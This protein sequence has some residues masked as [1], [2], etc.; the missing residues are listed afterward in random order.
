[1]WNFEALTIRVDDFFSNWE[2]RNV[3][4]SSKFLSNGWFGCSSHF[5]V[6]VVVVDI[7]MTL[8]RNFVSELLL[9]CFVTIKL[10]L[11]LFC[12]VLFVWVPVIR[13]HAVRSRV[14]N[15][16]IA[17]AQQRVRSTVKNKHKS[18]HIKEIRSWSQFGFRSCGKIHADSWNR[19]FCLSSF[20]K[21][22]LCEINVYSGLCW[23]CY[24][25]FG[26]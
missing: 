19:R 3:Y 11:S 14:L 2:Q 15:R 5:T 1:M 21:Q 26:E 22:I 9:W 4:F 24:S 20:R 25:E 7:L 8:K 18:T 23:L 6:V 17:T 13:V 12:S 16:S 10:P